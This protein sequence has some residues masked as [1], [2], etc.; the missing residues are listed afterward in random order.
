MFFSLIIPVY[1]R[2]EEVDELLESL[3]K[4]DYNEG[5]EVVIIEDGS[6]LKCEEVVKKYQSKLT[7]SYYYKDNSGPGDSRNY[8]MKKQRGLLYYLIPI[9]LFH[10]NIFG[11]G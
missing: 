5:F 11:S 7:I 10:R 9:V 3:S 4:S 1:N 2:P 6:S 8:G